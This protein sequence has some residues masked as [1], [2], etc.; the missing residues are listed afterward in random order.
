M[1]HHC[2]L[3][4]ALALALVSAPLLFSQAPSAAGEVRAE[5]DTASGKVGGADGA[6]TAAAAGYLLGPE[7]TVLIR[8]LNVDEFGTLPYPIDLGGNLN[9]PLAGRIHAAGITVE[10]LEAEIA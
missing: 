4:S 10:Q 3:H 8:A 9:I 6:S 7:D 2:A 5:F 1:P